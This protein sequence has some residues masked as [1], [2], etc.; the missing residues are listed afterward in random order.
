MAIK[1]K[2]ETRVFTSLAGGDS[3]E[4]TRKI[5]EFLKDKTDASVTYHNV[6]GAEFTHI[7]VTVTATPV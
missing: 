4:L 3:E 5:N 1:R 6:Q 7:F 2:S